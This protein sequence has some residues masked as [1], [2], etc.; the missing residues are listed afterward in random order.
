MAYLAQLHDNLNK[1]SKQHEALAAIFNDFA[2]FV[3]DCTQSP[4]IAS[5]SITAILH[6]DHGFFVTTYA[7][8]T[9]SFVFTSA[10][11][12]DGNMTGS[13]TCYLKKNFP[14]QQ[15]VEFGGFTFNGDG[16]T[17]INIPNSNQTIQIANDLGTLLMALHFIYDSLSK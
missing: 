14:E 16:Q 11:E 5:H 2:N 8:R 10:M 4:S 1:A 12:P 9:V 13:V 6:L 3:K 17:N 15:Q 7:G